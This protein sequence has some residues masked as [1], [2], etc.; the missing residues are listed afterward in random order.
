MIMP[1][2][3]SKATLAVSRVAT[4]VLLAYLYSLSCRRE[5]RY[6]SSQWHKEEE[7]NI[8]VLRYPALL[9]P[10]VY[11]QKEANQR[12]TLSYY[13]KAR[14]AQGQS[15]VLGEANF[16]KLLGKRHGERNQII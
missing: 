16:S 4:S 3:S 14:R 7:N 12:R 11:G 6:R 10:G 13:V 9:N 8:D 2:S 5:A 15:L 1:I